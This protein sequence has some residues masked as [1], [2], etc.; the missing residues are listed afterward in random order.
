M[1]QLNAP[2]GKEPVIL[3]LAV[4]AVG[5]AAAFYLFFVVDKYALLYYWDA[6]SHSVAARKFIDWGEIRD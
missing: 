5:L 4:I 2:R 1:L 6:V 3:F